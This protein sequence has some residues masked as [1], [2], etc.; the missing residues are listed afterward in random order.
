MT[1]ETIVGQA[2]AMPP[3]ALLKALD[4]WLAETNHDNGHPWRVSI[5]RTLETHSRVA[6]EDELEEL[7]SQA[8]DAA[9]VALALDNRIGHLCI[10][11]APSADDLITA[12]RCARVTADLVTELGNQL[13]N[14]AGEVHHG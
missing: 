7:Q 6:W 9:A 4:G 12:A 13:G 1:A 8:Y 10:A 3:L 11:S 14:L 5:A 2:V